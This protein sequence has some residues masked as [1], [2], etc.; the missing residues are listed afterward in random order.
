MH[1]EPDSL[2]PKSQKSSNRWKGNSVIVEELASAFRLVCVSAK[3]G[4]CTVVSVNEI[5]VEAKMCTFTLEAI[6]ILSSKSVPSILPTVQVPNLA[7]NAK[8]HETD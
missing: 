5:L 1:K 2:G 4:T 8:S 3:F 6:R 7:L